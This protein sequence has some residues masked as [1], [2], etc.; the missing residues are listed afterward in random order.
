[1]KKAFILPL[2]LCYF[3]AASGCQS[4]QADQTTED[5][6]GLNKEEKSQKLTDEEKKKLQSLGYV[7]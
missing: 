4:D 2:I 6:K 3:L 1:M 5:K 7:E